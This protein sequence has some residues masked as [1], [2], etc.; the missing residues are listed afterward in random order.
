MGKFYEQEISRQEINF[1]S[2]I[3][4]ADSTKEFIYSIFDTDSF[5]VY[6]KQLAKLGI[7]KINIL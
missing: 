2:E 6:I 1:L 3:N 4:D 7:I 5:E